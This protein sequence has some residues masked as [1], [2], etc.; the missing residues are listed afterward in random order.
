MVKAFNKYVDIASVCN[1]NNFGTQ[2]HQRR[3]IR[4]R[5]HLSYHFL[6]CLVITLKKE[7]VIERNSE[8]PTSN[9]ENYQTHIKYKIYSFLR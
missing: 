7:Y 9:T 4:V 5:N 3:V 1:L 2:T 6:M 8:A